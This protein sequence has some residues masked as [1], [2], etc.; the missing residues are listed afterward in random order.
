MHQFSEPEI[1]GL[2]LGR[3]GS[4]PNT[5]WCLSASS[6][7]ANVLCRQSGSAIRRLG[8]PW[9]AGFGFQVAFADADQLSAGEEDGRKKGQPL[10]CSLAGLAAKLCQ[11]V[12][13]Q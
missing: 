13:K 4:S 1:H 12:L 3:C 5:E 2:T 6:H 11:S 7:T 10:G 9:L 8:P